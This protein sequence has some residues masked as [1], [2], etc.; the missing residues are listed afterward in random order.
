MHRSGRPGATLLFQPTESCHAL[1]SR[2]RRQGSAGAQIRCNKRS[3]FYFLLFPNSKENISTR[4]GSN[5]FWFYWS[6]LFCSSPTLLAAGCFSSSK[7][8]R[9]GCKFR[10]ARR[11]TVSGVVVCS[12]CLPWSTEE[13]SPKNR[14]LLPSC[15]S[16]ASLH[17]ASL[18]LTARGWT[19]V[20]LKCI[21]TVSQKR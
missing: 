2:V 1:F 16:T 3:L 11:M 9:S 12:S 13:K 10:A 14:L 21:G 6:G 20:L 15:S 5:V 17:L 7:A 18:F 4:F 19:E 8:A